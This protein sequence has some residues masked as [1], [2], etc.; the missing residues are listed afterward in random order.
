MRG[1]Q[2]IVLNSITWP[3]VLLK[4]AHKS[5]LFLLNSFYHC[6]LCDSI[7]RQSNSST[8]STWTWRTKVAALKAGIFEKNP[9]TTT[10]QK[11]GTMGKWGAKSLTSL[12]CIVLS[13]QVSAHILGILF[14]LRTKVVSIPFLDLFSVQVCD[15]FENE[16]EALKK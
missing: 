3:Q 15:D 12:N 4:C 7:S 14:K 6:Y 11:R 2:N 8:I 13:F 9:Y 1:H 16:I 10:Y 5:R